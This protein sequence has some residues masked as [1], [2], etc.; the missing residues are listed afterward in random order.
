MA[1]AS[2]GPGL[3]ILGM[4]ESSGTDMSQA[5]LKKLVLGNLAALQVIG[6][7]DKAVRRRHGLVVGASMGWVLKEESSGLEPS[8]GVVYSK[9]NSFA[10]RCGG[11]HWAA[12]G[13]D[14]SSEG[15]LAGC[16]AG[17]LKPL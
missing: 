10:A 6:R 2:D 12:P 11:C 9:D 4:V 8:S 16:L 5:S 3:G 15:C 1:L 14:L 7:G 13:I 17:C